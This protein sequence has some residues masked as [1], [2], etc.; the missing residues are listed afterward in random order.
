M[1]DPEFSMLPAHLNQQVQLVAVKGILTSFVSL[2]CIREMIDDEDGYLSAKT[3]KL[4]ALLQRMVN[5]HVHQGQQQGV[6]LV[7]A[8]QNVQRVHELSNVREY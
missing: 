8:V 4:A 6:T 1:D 3:E 2:Q 5:Q 7:D